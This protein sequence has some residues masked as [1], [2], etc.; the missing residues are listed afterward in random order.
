MLPF[1]FIHL[2]L[3]HASNSLSHQGTPATVRNSCWN[4]PLQIRSRERPLGNSPLV[5]LL[6][7]FNINK[8][9]SAFKQWFSNWALIHRE[10]LVVFQRLR[11][12]DKLFLELEVR[13]KSK[14]MTSFSHNISGLF[15]ISSNKTSFLMLLLQMVK[16]AYLVWFS[17]SV[18]RREFQ[19]I[20]K[21]H[22]LH[23]GWFLGH[24]GFRLYSLKLYPRC[25][26]SIKS[27]TWLTHLFSADH[28]IR[29]I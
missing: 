3:R 16:G 1:H 7:W 18:Q 14:Y 19:Q 4:E 26:S 2:H 15:S 9:R 17:I 11:W 8:R 28:I 10:T 29:Q 25:L 23:T 5:W 22:H 21:L 24:G 13:S 6:C 12:F 27:L 20:N